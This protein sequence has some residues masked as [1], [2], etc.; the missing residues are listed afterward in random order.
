MCQCA[1]PR[2]L[3]LGLPLRYP[4]LREDGESSLAAPPNPNDRASDLDVSRLLWSP[5]DLQ[6]LRTVRP[7]DGILCSR[8]ELVLVRIQPDALNV[9]IDFVGVLER[10]PERGLLA[11]DQRLLRGGLIGLLQERIV[12]ERVD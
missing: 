2:R 8:L 10:N 9:Q 12:D 1:Q 7:D 11:R 6:N 4:G 5:R 3:G